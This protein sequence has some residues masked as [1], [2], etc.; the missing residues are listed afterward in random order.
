MNSVHKEARALVTGLLEGLTV[1]VTYRHEKITVPA[2]LIRSP[3]LWDSFV[4]EGAHGMKRFTDRVDA[5]DQPDFNSAMRDLVTRPVLV[6]AQGQ[7]ALKMPGGYAILGIG[8]GGVSCTKKR[9]IIS[10]EQQLVENPNMSASQTAHWLTA[11][12]GL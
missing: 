5:D 10:W 8:T 12:Q 3:R 7:W 4:K 2:N 9:Q 1:T 6:P 11:R